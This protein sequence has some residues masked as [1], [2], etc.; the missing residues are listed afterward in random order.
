MPVA[1]GYLPCIFW[2]H[3]EEV[4]HEPSCKSQLPVIAA[5]I[6]ETESQNH[7]SHKVE[8]RGRTDSREILIFGQ[9]CYW[10]NM[11]LLGGKVSMKK[12]LQGN[13]W[14]GR[15]ICRKSFFI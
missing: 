14:L 2:S 12:V 8:G 1:S 15:K 5:V 3:S 11:A 9:K 13:F 7:C 6:V 10:S 4:T